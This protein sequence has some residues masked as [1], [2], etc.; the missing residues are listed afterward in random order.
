MLDIRASFRCLRVRQTAARQWRISHRSTRFARRGIRE[1]RMQT[2]KRGRSCIYVGVGG[3]LRAAR[4]IFMGRTV[5]ISSRSCNRPS[6][7]GKVGSVISVRLDAALLNS[8]LRPA[9]TMLWRSSSETF[10]PMSRSSSESRFRR[11]Q[12]S[13]MDESFCWHPKTLVVGTQADEGNCR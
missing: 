12:N 4:K 8:S 9:M 5:S 1:C 3:G 2:L 13:S 11:V 7:L 10:L 6:T